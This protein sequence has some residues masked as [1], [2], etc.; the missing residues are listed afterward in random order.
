[1][2]RPR[3]AMKASAVVVIEPETAD[4]GLDMPVD[5]G[6]DGVDL[7]GECCVGQA[8]I[9]QALA[10]P[11]PRGHQQATAF[12]ERPEPALRLRWRR[13]RGQLI[14]LAIE[15]AGQ[16]VGIG[17]IVLVPGIDAFPVVHELAGVDQVHAVTA[18]TG[19]VQHG[20]MVAP[21][22]FEC[23]V[24]RPG[25]SIEPGGDGD[26][27]V[28]EGMGTALFEV[29]EHEFA[30]ADVDAEGAIAGRICHNGLRG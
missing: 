5:A 23:D 22:G 19:G 20:Q 17:G 15:E 8:D 6:D 24:Q 30:L 18:G 28:V 9:A 2:S 14:D 3:Y 13:D 25:L 29:M 4:Q 26:V 1:M 16:Q 10:E 21:G 12:D 7:G 27:G 11:G